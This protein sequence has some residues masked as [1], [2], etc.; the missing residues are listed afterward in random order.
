MGGHC[1]RIFHSNVIFE[2]H[3]FSLANEME[4][5]NLSV[6]IMQESMCDSWNG[7]TLVNSQL[8]EGKWRCKENFESYFP[9]SYA[10]G[11]IYWCVGMSHEVDLVLDLKTDGQ[12]ASQH[13]DTSGV[14]I[15]DAPYLHAILFCTILSFP[16][17][18]WLCV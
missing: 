14:S 9:H 12:Y 8:Y 7:R 15:W 11:K 3:T 5:K 13:L 17:R 2:E 10:S 16:I 6:R 1:E 18:L 4:L